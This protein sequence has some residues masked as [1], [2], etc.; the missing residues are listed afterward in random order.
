[1]ARQGFLTRGRRY[2]RGD[3]SPW[4]FVG[5]V[6]M[7]AVFFLYAASGP[8]TPWWAQAL[9]LVLWLVATVRAVRWWSTHPARVAWVPVGCALVWFVAVW[10]GAAWL[11]W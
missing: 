8:F 9:L 11:D 4:P 2:R 10:V 7:A 3:V 6:G 5:L 1:M